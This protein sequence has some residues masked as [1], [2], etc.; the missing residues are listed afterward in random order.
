MRPQL[1][2]A[3]RQLWRDEHTLQLGLDPE[4]AGVL[5]GLD[6][7]AVQLLARMDGT[8]TAAQLVHSAGASGADAA[9][10][11]ELIEGLSHRGLLVD[12]AGGD[13]AARA[14]DPDERGRLE[15]DLAAWSVGAGAVGRRLLAVRR[16]SRVVV[17]GAGRLGAL[18]VTLLAAAAVGRL[19]VTDDG[20]VRAGDLGPG[21]HERATVGTGRAASAAQ[22]AALAAPSARVSCSRSPVPLDA[23]PPDLVVVSP[24]GPAPP[25]GRCEQL[26]AAGV[27][28]L[29][30]TTFERVAV[31]GPLVLPGRSP[32]TTCLDLHRVDRDR[33]W[34]VVASQLHGAAASVTGVRTVAACDVVLASLAAS[35][36][37]SAALAYLDAPG[38]PHELAGAMVQV[39]PPGLLAR[40]RSWTWHPSCGCS[41]DSLDDSGSEGTVPAGTTTTRPSAARASP[42]SWTRRTGEATVHSTDATPPSAASSSVGRRPSQAPHTP[43]ARAPSGRTP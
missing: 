12:A 10:T 27:P 41:W 21:G 37:A 19:V 31:V 25:P 4:H 5:A 39:R 40:R 29:L 14:I 24:D 38:E 20:Q 43:P 1:N 11:R 9:A 35:L 7:A 2:P 23:E 13:A 6:A 18:L 28:H 32:C 15:P 30:A 16:R 34:P 33:Q 8:R 17:E 26:L 22:R 42:T 3:L 36:A